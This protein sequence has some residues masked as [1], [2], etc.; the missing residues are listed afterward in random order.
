[1][2][3]INQPLFSAQGHKYLAGFIV[4]SGGEPQRISVEAVELM[5]I[6]HVYRKRLGD[7]SNPEMV[8]SDVALHNALDG[9]TCFHYSQL[10]SILQQVIKTPGAANAS[11]DQCSKT[12]FDNWNPIGNSFF[13]T[14]G[15]L[16]EIMVRDFTPVFQY[17]NEFSF[18]EIKCFVRWYL[19]RHQQE[20]VLRSNPNVFLTHGHEW[21]QVLRV[22][23]F[24]IKQLP[25]LIHRQIC[26]CAPPP[27]LIIRHTS[28]GVQKF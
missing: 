7:L 16:R 5:V 2:I 1:M 17:R 4:A 21:E 23:C 8:W 10:K 9:V 6:N 25:S 22:R 27:A 13:T 28:Q 15:A 11:R 3:M 24:H 26:P 18:K 20:M 19:N 12:V 14:S